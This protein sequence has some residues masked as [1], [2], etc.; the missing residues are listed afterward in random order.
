MVQGMFAS[1]PAYN[2]FLEPMSL[3]AYLARTHHPPRLTKTQADKY[4]V[5][6]P[7]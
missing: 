1:L 2:P 6:Y 3:Q 7:G 5:I 4:I